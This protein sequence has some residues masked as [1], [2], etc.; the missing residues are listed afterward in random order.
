[1][2]AEVGRGSLAADNRTLRELIMGAFDQQLMLDRAFKSKRITLTSNR[3]A[4]NEQ[5][6]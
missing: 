1:M 2:G 4:N 3:R 6:D 5:T